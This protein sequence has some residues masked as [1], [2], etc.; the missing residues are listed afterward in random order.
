VRDYFSR[1]GYHR[2]PADHPR[3]P[4]IYSLKA[5]KD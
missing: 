1:D 2:F 3:F 4:L 5:V